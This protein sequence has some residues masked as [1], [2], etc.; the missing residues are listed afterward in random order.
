MLEFFMGISGKNQ[1]LQAEN[2][3]QLVTHT[4]HE[5]SQVTKVFRLIAFAI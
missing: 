5:K 2:I 1:L 3:Y 4:L